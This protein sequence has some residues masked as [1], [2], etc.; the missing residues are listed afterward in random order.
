MSF[1]ANREQNVVSFSKHCLSPTAAEK[2]WD[3][4]PEIWSIIR[5]YFYLALSIR[6]RCGC[7]VKSI[8]VYRVGR[9]Q[10]I[11]AHVRFKTTEG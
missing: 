8:R 4:D 7:V 11:V 2:A 5:G 3:S 9:E 1:E 6:L 10:N